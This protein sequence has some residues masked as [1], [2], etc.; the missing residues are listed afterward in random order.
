VE[1]NYHYYRAFTIL[2]LSEF[3]Y[4]QRTGDMQKFLLLAEGI[5]SKI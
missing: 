1:F 2:D 3:E 4:F 5:R